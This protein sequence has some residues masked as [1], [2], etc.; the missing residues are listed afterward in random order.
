MIGKIYLEIGEEGAIGNK[1]KNGR[2]PGQGG[3]TNRPTHTAIKIC[4][5][6]TP[7]H[8]RAIKFWSPKL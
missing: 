7:L 8:P 2:A 5:N 6:T 3:T 4:K 1:K